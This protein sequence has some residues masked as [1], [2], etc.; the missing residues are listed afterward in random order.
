L[1]ALRVC[2][3]PGEHPSSLH[4]NVSL[5]EISV[6][7]LAIRAIDYLAIDYNGG[8]MKSDLYHRFYHVIQQIPWGRV[9]TYGQVAAMAGYPGYARQVG[10]ALHAT[11]KD[12]DIPWHRVIN[13]QGMVSLQASD[14]EDNLQRLL[15][16]AEGVQFDQRNRVSLKKYQWKPENSAFIPPGSP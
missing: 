11:P 15:L 3:A 4:Q 6:N 2:I 9:A 13:A 16:K 14:S 8:M 1:E 5:P 10:Y 12:L 7:V